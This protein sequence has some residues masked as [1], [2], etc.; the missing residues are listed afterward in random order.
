[1]QVF[2]RAVITGFGLALGAAIYK[3]VA[4]ELGLD[5]SAAQP[6]VAATGSGEPVPS[7]T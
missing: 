5:D 3:R 1:M 4:K 2:V 6:S 7:T